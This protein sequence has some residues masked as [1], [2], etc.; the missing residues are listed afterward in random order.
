MANMRIIGKKDSKSRKDITDATGIKLYTGQNADAIINYGLAGHKLEQFFRKYPSANR[1]PVINKYVGRS[2]YL[3]VKDA[4][5]KDILVPE[6]CLSLPRMAKL[7]DWIEK[8]IHSSQG[9]GICKARKR[10]RLLGKY[11]QRMISDRRYELRVHAFLWLPQDQWGLHKRIGPEDQIAWNFHQGGH[12]QTVR[13]SNGHGVF[14]EAKNIAKKILEIRNMAFGAVDLIVD[15]KMKVYFIEVNASPGFSEL[16]AGIYFEA[17]NELKNMS[18]R[19]VV[20]F[21][22]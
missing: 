2:K 21:G 17:M 22:R 5:D 7:P 8:R 6:S 12:F 15:N 11:Y 1:I 13:H 16:S 19:K 3:A 4:E 10:G 14:L 20:K 9:L 18:K